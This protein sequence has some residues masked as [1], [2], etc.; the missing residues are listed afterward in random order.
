MNLIVALNVNLD[1]GLCLGEITEHML[2]A[3]IFIYALILF[4]FEALK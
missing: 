1:T 3:S 4:S 2:I